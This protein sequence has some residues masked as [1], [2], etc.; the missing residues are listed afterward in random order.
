MKTFDTGARYS[1][2]GH[3]RMM[4]ADV[5][6]ENWSL[7]MLS[8]HSVFN[9]RYVHSVAVLLLPPDG[10]MSCCAAATN[11]CL[12]LR[13]HTFRLDGQVRAEWSRCPCSMARYA[14]DSVASLR[15]SS[16]SWMASRIGRLFAGAGRRHLVIICKAPLMAGVNAG[17]EHCG[18]RGERSTLRLRGSGPVA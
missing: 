1:W 8:N 10:L 11:G 5:G 6:Y 13:C 2:Q 3:S 12:D 7:L 15:R 17:C 18:A 4:G 14:R 16:A 9:R